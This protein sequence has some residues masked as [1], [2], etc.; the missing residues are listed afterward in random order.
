MEIKRVVA[1]YF[2][3]TGNTEKLAKA[4]ARAASEAAGLQPETLDFTRP[5]AREKTYEFGPDDLLIIGLP[6][7]AGRLPNK[8][9]PFVQENLKGD[10]TLSLPFVCFGNRA[11]DDGMAE[12]VYEQ[13]N[14]GF[15]P[16]AAAA[17]ATRHAFATSLAAGRP[18]E[19]DL[20][21]AKAIAL[22]LWKAVE[23]AES[24]E[25]F[26][27]LTVDGNTPPGPYYRPKRMDGEPAVFLKAKPLTDTDK[28]VGCGTCARVCSMGSIDSEDVTKVPGICIKCQACVTKCP[29]GAKYFDD[30]DFLSHK[31][32]LE[33][34][35]AEEK[36]NT[37]WT[38]LLK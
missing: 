18:K 1:A 29:M 31:E 33:T 34:N 36:T 5:E 11:F 10:D 3:P 7:Y 20:E 21:D 35:F 27:D 22:G 26:A 15:R 30:P 6:V 2:S 14:T 9:L 37:V 25:D 8:I 17:F 4:M 38:C 13:K 28:C 16:A 19:A 23:A 24:A 32:M 12:L